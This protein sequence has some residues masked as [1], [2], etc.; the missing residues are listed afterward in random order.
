MVEKGV[1]C[2]PGKVFLGDMMVY[3]FDLQPEDGHRMPAFI[4]LQQYYA[5]AYLVDRVQQLPKIDLRWR[6]KVTGLEQRNDHVVLEVETPD[7][8]YR[9]AATYVV[10]C[11]GARS[12]LRAMVGAD[13]QGKVFEDQFLIADVRMTAAFPTERWFWFDPPFHAGRSAL[14]HKQPDDVWRIDLQLSRDA[15]AA[16]ERRP[17]H[18]RPRIARTLGHDDFEFGWIWIYKL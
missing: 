8:S 10:A 3:Q 14:L 11:D 16:V 6:N 15:D 18:V 13:F 1:A 5:E 17:G 12:S 9:L 4:N 7:G 2:K